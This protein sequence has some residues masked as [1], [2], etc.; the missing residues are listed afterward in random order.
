MLLKKVALIVLALYTFLLI[1]ARVPMMQTLLYFSEL[2]LFVGLGALPCF[3]FL[4]VSL[5]IAKKNVTKETTDD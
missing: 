2:T 1:L 3:L 5:F 4:M